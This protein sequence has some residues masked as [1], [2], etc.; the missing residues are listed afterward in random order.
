[1]NM[2]DRIGIMNRGRVE[3]VGPPT[4][5]YERP[6]TTFIGRFLGEANLLGGELR[7]LSGDVGTVALPGGLALRGRAAKAFAA[8]SRV[9]LFVRP[10]RIALSPESLALAA[11]G[12][13]R[14]AGRVRR[15][16]FLGNIVRY[17]VDAGGVEITVDVQNARARRLEAGEPV[18]LSWSVEDSLLL[19][20]AA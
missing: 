17:A 7:E 10:E 11:A 19:E 13:N 14:A 5:I 20:G 3:Q 15:T 16:S 9:S 1:M 6:D 12:A 18:T 8:G 4:E 2:S